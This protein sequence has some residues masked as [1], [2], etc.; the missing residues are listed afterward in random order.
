MVS[1]SLL[2]VTGLRSVNHSHLFCGSPDE[3]SAALNEKAGLDL[4]FI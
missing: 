1:R 3:N 2:Q 4:D